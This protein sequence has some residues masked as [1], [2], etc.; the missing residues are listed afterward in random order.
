MTTSRS[1]SMN[2]AKIRG[3]YPNLANGGVRRV[4]IAVPKEHSL[5]FFS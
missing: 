5:Y 3:K 1:P 4:N 2:L